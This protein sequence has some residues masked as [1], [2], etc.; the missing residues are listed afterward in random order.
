MMYQFFRFFPGDIYQREVARQIAT[1]DWVCPLMSN[2]A[3]ISL[4][5]LGV[6]L[7]S[8]GGIPRY[9]IIQN[10]RLVTFVVN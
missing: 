10:E 7:H 3:Q 9:K 6:L 8:L 5:S 1:F 2:Q 4:D